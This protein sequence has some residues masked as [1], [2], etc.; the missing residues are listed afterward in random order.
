MKKNVY[1]ELSCNEFLICLTKYIKKKYTLENFFKQLNIKS[2]EKLTS[3]P[4]FENNYYDVNKI[5]YHRPH[6]C[7][8]VGKI[9]G[10]QR[11]LSQNMVATPLCQIYLIMDVIG[12]KDPFHVK[13]YN[14]EKHNLYNLLMNETDFDLWTKL[15]IYLQI[16]GIKIENIKNILGYTNHKTYRN[17]FITGKTKL[18]SYESIF[19]TFGAKLTCIIPEDMVLDKYKDYA[20]HITKEEKTNEI[21]DSYVIEPNQLKRLFDYAYEKLKADNSIK[22]KQSDTKNEQNDTNISK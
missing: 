8:E 19:D 7:Y 22:K 21:P 4:K 1:Y 13:F 5:H 12:L 18:T 3:I 16:E 10:I 14:K 2:T 11:K 15:N 17:T 20:T 9:S 6:E